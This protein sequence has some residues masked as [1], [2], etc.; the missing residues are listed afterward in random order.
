MQEER[1]SETEVHAYEAPIVEEL[2]LSQGPCE[3]GSMVT[4]G[5]A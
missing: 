5:S 2:D 3:T 1:E 4:T